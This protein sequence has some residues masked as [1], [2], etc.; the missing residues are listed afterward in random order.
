MIRGSI[1]ALVTP[2]DQDGHVDYRRLGELINWHIEWGTDAV[3]V[4]GT[5]GETPALSEE[6]QEEI[7]RASIEEAGGRYPRHS[8]Q[9]LQQHGKD[10]GQ[11]CEI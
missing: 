5:T 10:G 11:E 1:V 2:F 9:R 7:V 6:E 4:L 8:Q 3:L